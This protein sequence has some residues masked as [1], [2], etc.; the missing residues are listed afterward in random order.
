MVVGSIPDFGVNVLS[1][2]PLGIM[3]AVG[4]PYIVFIILRYI[5]FIS[6]FCRAF[7]MKGC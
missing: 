3:L 7:A 4:L 1:V 5:P 2:S 6:S